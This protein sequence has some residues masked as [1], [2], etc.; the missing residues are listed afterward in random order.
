MLIYN[1]KGFLSLSGS[2]LSLVALGNTPRLVSLCGKAE[3]VL[4]P[5][6]EAETALIWNSRQLPPKAVHDSSCWT[7]ERGVVA[8]KFHGTD[9][10]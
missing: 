9:I 2:A 10:Y 8:Q 7:Y 3:R 6:E 5:K 4:F 1:N